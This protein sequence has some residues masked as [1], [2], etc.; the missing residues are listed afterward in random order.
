ML[1]SVS[2]NVLAVLGCAVAAMVIGFVWYGPLFGRIWARESGKSE[3]EMQN[4]MKKAGGKTYGIMFVTA[5]IM[6]YVLRHMLVY[7][8]STTVM[9][10]MTGAFWTWLGFVATI[11]TGGV[12]WEGKSWTWYLINAGYWLVTLGAM[13]AILVSMP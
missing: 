9:D 2:V 3:K 12:L 8:Q 5:L 13:G 1:G 11:Q 10:G 6:A 4:A 7:S